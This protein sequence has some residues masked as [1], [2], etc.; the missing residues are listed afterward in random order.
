MDLL[1]GIFVPNRNGDHIWTLKEVLE[2]KR[3]TGRR[4]SDALTIMKHEMSQN[5]GT[6]SEDKNEKMW[7]E[8]VLKAAQFSVKLA[9]RSKLVSFVDSRPKNIFYVNEK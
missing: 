6:G 3:T 5:S 8:T 9:A 1:L 2:D 7:R 4:A